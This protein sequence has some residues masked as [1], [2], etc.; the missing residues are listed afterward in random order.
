[1][2]IKISPEGISQSVDGFA[3]EHELIKIRRVDQNLILQEK[4]HPQFDGVFHPQDGEKVEEVI[5]EEGKLQ[6]DLWHAEA[7]GIAQT[8]KSD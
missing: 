3:Y 6:G 8:P 2:F 1:M 5:V 7:D 4:A